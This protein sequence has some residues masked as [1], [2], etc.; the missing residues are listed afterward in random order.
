MKS[1]N[2]SVPFI[3]MI[4]IIAFLLLVCI[5]LPL[6]VP[7]WSERAFALPLMG[8]GLLLPFVHF[9]VFGGSQVA[10]QRRERKNSGEAK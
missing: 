9:F 5:F 4:V 2:G 1:D 10:R 6:F 8:V 7:N 3:A